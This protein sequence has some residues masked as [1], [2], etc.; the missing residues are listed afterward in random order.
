MGKKDVLHDPDNLRS[1]THVN[2]LQLHVS[3]ENFALR[4][5]A[6]TVAHNCSVQ[7]YNAAGKDSSPAIGHLE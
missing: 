6:P 1:G 7:V 2:S 4:K 5:I 3:D